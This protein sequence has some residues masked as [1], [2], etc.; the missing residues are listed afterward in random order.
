MYCCTYHIFHAAAS[1][2]VHGQ[3]SRGGLHTVAAALTE[4]GSSVVQFLQS[5]RTVAF[6][7]P[8]LVTDRTW[9]YWIKL[10]TRTGEQTVLYFCRA[11]VVAVS[12]AHVGVASAI[13]LATTVCW[14]RIC[15]CENM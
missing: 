11:P 4:S 9:L 1:Q 10:S 15:G 5:V 7:V 3:G 13:T 8:L 6:A 14:T 2:V 12:V